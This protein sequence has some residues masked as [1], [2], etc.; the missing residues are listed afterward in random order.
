M[1]ATCPLISTAGAGTPTGTVCTATHP[2]AQAALLARGE[3]SSG[4][5]GLCKSG[6]QL[7]VPSRALALGHPCRE[8]GGKCQ[9]EQAAPSLSLCINHGA[10][11]RGEGRGAPRPLPAHGAPCPDESSAGLLWES[12]RSQEGELFEM[13]SWKSSPNTPDV[14]GLS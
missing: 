9:A 6:S 7:P 14:S 4:Q 13:R 2:C 12:W 3:D 5:K 11:T 8:H 10:P 1:A